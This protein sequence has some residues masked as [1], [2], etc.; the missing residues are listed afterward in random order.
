[1][2][3]AKQLFKFVGVGSL[4]GAYV[5]QASIM[6]QF[7]GASW[8]SKKK[9]ARLLRKYS[10]AGLKLLDMEVIRDGVDLVETDSRLYVGNHLS[11]TDILVYSSFLPTCFVTSQ[12]IRE[13]PVL[14]FLCDVA[15]CLFVER[16]SRENLQKEVSQISEGLENGCNVLVYPEA[17]STNGDGVLRFKRPLFAAAVY[18]EKLV[19]PFTINYEAVNGKP[20]DINNRDLLFWYGDMDFF[21]HLWD[22]CGQ[23]GIR[24]RLTF[25]KAIEAKQ[26]D[27]VSDLAAVAHK[28]V[29]EAFVSMQTSNLNGVDV[30]SP[31]LAQSPSIRNGASPQPRI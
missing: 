3:K 14:G 25:H 29:S 6:R 22:L 23:E 1:M 4:I 2:N 28:A 11:Y 13:T 15:G 12:E 31:S 9:T 16:R 30:E 20:V 27:D 17:T 19:Q 5:A 7:S 18:A 24:V 26:Y 8:V 10:Q 21:P